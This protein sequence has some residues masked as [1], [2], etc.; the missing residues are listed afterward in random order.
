[1]SCVVGAGIEPAASALSWQRSNLLSYA[2]SVN[3][4]QATYRR[5]PSVS[6]GYIVCLIIGVCLGVWFGTTRLGVWY[7]LYKLGQAEQR[8]RQRRIRG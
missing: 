7:A 8:D 3:T 5:V 1:M 6:V 4:G 2:T